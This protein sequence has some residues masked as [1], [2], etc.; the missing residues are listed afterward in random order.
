MADESG[1]EKSLPASGQKKQRARDQGNIAR[2]QDLTA[3]LAL[4]AALFAL[5][6]LS[7][8]IWTTLIE[9]MRHYLEDTIDILPTRDSMTFVAAEMVWYTALAVLPFM[10]IMMVFGVAANVL[11][12]G[13]VASSQALQ[14]KFDRLNPISGLRRFFS[15][16]IVI[17]LVKAVLKLII[18]GWI[19]WYGV[20]DR[21]GEVLYSI[22]LTPDTLAWAVSSLV[23]A[24]WWRVV[25]AMLVLG[26][27]DYGVQRWMHERDLRMTV[28]EAREEAR[29]LEGDPRIKQRIRSIQRQMAMQRMMAEVPTADVVITNPTTFAVALRYDVRTMTAPVV[30]AKGA[31]ILAERI[32]DVAMEHHV[33]IVQKPEL[34]RALYH[35]IDVNRPVPE[36]LFVAVAEVLAFVYEIDRRAEKVRERQEAARMR[37]AGAAIG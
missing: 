14:P 37:P 30:V 20:R 10:L 29:Q 26:I 34:A 19:V 36:G 22:H 17:E 12:V 28:Q 24:I 9:T 25:L 33:P 3:G 5:W 27:L 23:V 1:G 16:R 13:F 2:S 31:R 8:T 32:R 11:Q 21:L 7:G 18:V 6:I 4:L 15:M 35:T